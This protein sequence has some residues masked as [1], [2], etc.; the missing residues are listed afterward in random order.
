M[1]TSPPSITAIPDFPSISDRVTYNAKAYAWATALDNVTA[2]EIS[3]VATNVY[4][5]SVGAA[6]DAI[7]A[8]T[9]ATTASTAALT[10]VNAPGTGGTSTTSLTISTGT[11]SFTTQTGKAWSVGQP[12]VIAR[13]SAPASSLMYGTITSY[14]TGTGAMVVS[15][16]NT[17]GSGTFTD[18]SISLTGGYF[19][20]GSG[21]GG[22]VITGSVT[23]TSTSSA[24]ISVTPSTYGLYVTLPDATTC[25]KA[26]NLFSV[27]N[28]GDYDYGV[29]D[30]TGTQLGWVRAK[31]GA[32]IGLADSSTAAGVWVPYGL[33]KLGVTAR[34]DS[35]TVFSATM[36]PVELDTNRTCFVLGGGSSWYGVVFDKSTATWG[37]AVYLGVYSNGFGCATL[38]TTN[39]VLVSI[40]TASTTLSTLTLTVSG[41]SVTANTVVNTTIGGSIGAVAAPSSLIAV[42]SSFVVSYTSGGAPEIRAI[43]VSGTTPTV[44]SASALNNAST[45]NYPARLYAAGSVVRTILGFNGTTAACKPFTVSGTTLTAGTELTFTCYFDGVRVIDNGTGNLVLHYNTAA[46][47]SNHSLSILKL[48][49]T[50]EAITTVTISGAAVGNIGNAS[51]LYPMSTGK[52]FFVQSYS[53]STAAFIITDTAGTISVSS[54]LDGILTHAGNN[55]IC[56]PANAAGEQSVVFTN[57]AVSSTTR[58]VYNVAGATPTLVSVAVITALSG[59]LAGITP[60]TVYNLAANSRRPVLAV[61]TTNYGLPSGVSAGVSTN[62]QQFTALAPAKSLSN[63]SSF[64][65]TSSSSNKVWGYGVTG[66]PVIQIEAAA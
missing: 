44:G 60:P 2:G 38:S 26:D 35:T 51:D 50:V 6:A 47:P 18:W 52:T 58:V 61:G 10:A 65:R 53:T 13:T 27:Y 9:A 31:T 21:Q 36:F 54:A 8:S 29:K 59:T 41:T 49:G 43:T 28:N 19:S 56:M 66:S 45:G 4:N 23:L 55:T 64:L 46:A 42:G 12:V 32:M 15:V 20:T 24:A 30:S 14:V 22:Q 7:T 63:S 39:Q 62:N 48:T 5:N 11:Q 17:T 16:A 33:E 1:P 34:L 57:S 37:A 40:C 25:T 3:A